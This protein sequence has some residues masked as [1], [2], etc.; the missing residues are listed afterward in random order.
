MMRRIVAA[1]ALALAL[2]PAASPAAPAAPPDAA[3]EKVRAELIEPFVAALALPDAEQSARATLPFVHPSLR[4]AS[5]DDL[6]ADVKRF[7]FKKARSNVGAYG[8]PVRVVRT[9][10]TAI[11]A[12]GPP[13]ASEAGTV[14]DYFLERKSGTPAPVRVFFPKESGR[15]TIAYMGSL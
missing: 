15:P 13:G 6:A 5:G 8:R 11:T 14:V 4:S 7:S 9:S 10:Q 2:A 12:V 1:G 3:A